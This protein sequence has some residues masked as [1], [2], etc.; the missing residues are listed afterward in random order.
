M[1]LKLFLLSHLCI[2]LDVLIVS[3]LHLTLDNSCKST[4][5]LAKL[6][7]D[8]SLDL[9]N[10][11]FESM[12]KVISSPDAIF[13]MG[14]NLSHGL[15]SSEII[16]KSISEVFSLLHSYFP[17][18][19]QIYT[20]GN[21]EGFN[22]NQT[23]REIA[24]SLAYL[25]EYWIPSS[26]RN[27]KFLEAGYYQLDI[28]EYL[29]IILNSNHFFK[30]TEKSG[31]QLEWLEQE[32]EFTTKEVIIFTHSPPIV[33]FFNGGS[34]LWEENNLQEFKRIVEKYGYLIKCIFAGHLHKGIVGVAGGIPVIA[35]PAISPVYFTYPAFRRYR[36]EGEIFDFTEYVLDINT[37]IW[38]KSYTYSEIFGDLHE[39][40]E[41]YDILK[42]DNELLDKYV[43][44]SRGYTEE[45]FPSTEIMW[46]HTTNISQELEN[47][48]IL[49]L[50]SLKDLSF[51]EFIECK[52]NLRRI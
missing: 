38:S 8:S 6:G 1:L 23:E 5:A 18:T 3:D 21:N 22:A 29:L 20:V 50:C 41:L 24:D 13:I 28:G 9:L 36:I 42:K 14:D 16:K 19:L 49:V 7:C 33:S 30:L 26:W 32:L 40:T 27:Y 31:P 44:L 46:K 45:T 47:N 51:I 52:N 39:I 34:E 12:S 17:T 25:Y 11:T 43:K 15:S 37:G 35:N 10:S 48:R 4:S 2:S